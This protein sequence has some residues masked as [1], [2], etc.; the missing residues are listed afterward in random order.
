M[1]AANARGA[2]GRDGVIPARL[3]AQ[4]IERTNIF[5]EALTRAVQG[6]RRVITVDVLVPII[7][8]QANHVALISDDVDERK[9]AVQA[10][11]SRIALADGLPRL[12]GEAERR[13]ICKLE[14]NDR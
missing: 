3:G 5:K 4:C 8:A 7:G 10:A 6:H 11:D 2:I 9:L 13:G 1:L 14:A 12:D